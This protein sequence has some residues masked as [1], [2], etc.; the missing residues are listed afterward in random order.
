MNSYLEK[1]KFLTV[2]LMLCFATQ[3]AQSADTLS[4]CSPSGKICLKVWLA[5]ELHY[6]IQYAGDQIIDASAIDLLLDNE[7]SLSKSAVIRSFSIKKIKEQI[8]SPVPE[9]RKIIP[10]QYNL[11]T[12]QF[13]QPYSVE[14]RAYDDGVAYRISTRFKDS[15]IVK[16]E[17]ARFAFKDQASGYFPEI[18]MAGNDDPFKTSFEDLYSFKKVSAFPSTSIAYTPILVVTPSYP[19]IAITESDLED[20]PGMFLQGTGKSRLQGVFARYPLEEKVAE[21]LYSQTRVTKKANFIARTKGTRTF[22]WRVIIIAAEDRYLPG[23]DLVYRL[24][25]PSRLN[26]VS[27]IKPGNITDEWIIDINLFNVPFKSGRNTASY[28]YYI[29]FASRFGF[30]RIMMDAGWSDN[31]D[32]FKINPDIDMDTL[33]AY[34]KQKGVKI[35]MWTLALTLDR[36]LEA[37]LQQFNQWGVDFIMTDFIDRDDQVSVN[38]HKRITEACAAHKIMIMFHG[39]YPPK[40]FNRTYPNA[41]TREGVLGSE[42]N[43]WSEKVTPDHDVILPFTRMLAGSMDY[44]PGMLYNANKKSFRM[45]EGIVYSQGTRAHQAAL[46]IIFDSPIQFFAGNPSQGFLEPAYME[47]IGQLPTTWEETI[48]LDAKVGEYIVTARKHGDNWYIGGITGWT[49][50]DINVKFDFLNVGD[51]TATFC[52]DGVNADHYAADYLLEQFKV[53]QQ[54]ELPIHLAPGGGFLLKIERL[55]NF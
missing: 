43:I 29:D 45:I 3:Q 52:K 25:A 26:D 24:G 6:S 49:E 30:D 41:I 15:I 4:V 34:A 17:V 8:I 44:E 27:W 47:L 28:K 2:I 12:L 18:P 54:T 10:D 51:Y 53:N 35:A 48:I 9:K 38:F 55:K 5:V 32:L 31:N 46:P 23:N 50:R 13:K 39:T 36:Q 40:G 37:A 42:Y 11:L 14:F 19:K 1:V 16:D 33:V 7:S 21:A 22:P 20:Y